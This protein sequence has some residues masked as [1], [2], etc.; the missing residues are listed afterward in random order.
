MNLNIF[1][2]TVPY[3]AIHEPYSA[4]LAVN[5][6]NRLYSAIF[7]STLTYSAILGHTRTHWDILG[8][9]QPYLDIAGHKPLFGFLPPI[10]LI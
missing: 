2:H 9:I 8:H 4:I 10:E 5:G 6:H 3:S 1:V 7:G